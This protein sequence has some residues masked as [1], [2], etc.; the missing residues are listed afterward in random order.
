MIKVWPSGFSLIYPIL[1]VLLHLRLFPLNRRRSDSQQIPDG[2]GA[3]LVARLLCH[4]R[5]SVAVVPAAVPGLH[6][7][8]A[9]VTADG[10]HAAATARA[11]DGGAVPV[12]AGHPEPYRARA[13][14]DR[15][16]AGGVAP[17][18]ATAG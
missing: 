16:A 10:R 1:N 15:Q 8:A 4:R 17:E 14:D 2:D 5:V 12:P 18:L 11:H 13:E 7:A 3:G 6:A 9:A